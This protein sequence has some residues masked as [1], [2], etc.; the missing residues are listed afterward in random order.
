[1]RNH[2]AMPFAAGEATLLGS[3]VASH[4]N[5]RLALVVVSLL[6]AAFILTV[7]AASRPFP[8]IPAFVPTYNA[9]VMILSLITAVL[10]YSQYCELK[11]RSLLALVSGYLFM[12][13]MVA[14]HGI[15][16]PG[17][18]GPGHLIGGRQTS[19][20][21]WIAWHGL[22]PLFVAA[23]ALFAQRERRDGK[24]EARAATHRDTVFAF[25]GTL[26]LAAALILLT[27]AGEAL[28][29]ELMLGH[30]Y[31]SNFPRLIMSAAWGSH[32]IALGLLIKSTRG[33]RVIDLWVGVTL[34]SATIDL[35][36]SGIFVT[37]RYQLGFYVGR[38]YEL[39]ASSFVLTL[40][41]RQAVRL[42]G[43]L[44]RAMVALRAS[45]E[46][47][48][49]LIESVHDYAIFTLDPDG[50]VMSWNEGA[51][52][53]N[54][55]TTEE[56]IGR[57]VECFYTQED[58]AAGK[59]RREMET[60]LET[61]HSEN[62]SWRVRKDGSLF[63]AN[64]VMT[65]LKADDGALLGFTKISRDLTERKQL[66]DA[67]RRSH[68]DLDQR[69]RERTLELAATNRQLEGEVQERRAAEE[70]VKIL[71]R[72]LVTAQEE[73]RRRIA[74]DI[75]DQ[76]GQQM[77]ALRMSLSTL[78]FKCDKRTE[79]TEH[80]RRTEELANDLDRSIDFLTW[81]LRPAGLEHFSLSVALGTLVD[82]WS[83]YFQIMAEYFA[84]GV[85]H[86][87]L[88]PEAE[89][90]L[91]RLAQEALHNIYKHAE[92]S[93]VGVMFERHGDLVV[94]VIED[95]GRGFNPEE[96]RAGQGGTGMGLIGMR[97]RAALAGGKL[98]VESSP[99]VGTTIYVQI[100]LRQ[101]GANER[102]RN[103]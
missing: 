31:R 42:H 69:V 86:L 67:L 6:G 47:L 3:A 24:N 70:R 2:I 49:G 58:V 91:Y 19:V 84:S 35:A 37:G 61:G 83:G 21:L 73:E 22:F 33:R 29:P 51:R 50:R 16:F 46:R 26:A 23:Y 89:I 93:H 40:L 72:Q 1:M 27:T 38:I 65:P 45:E 79:L 57:T 76:M 100:S 44:A 39:L 53:I 82:G 102:K 15:S 14:A 4:E 25:L 52:R 7:P 30:N 63:W 68:D 10:L 13:I 90:N 66:E 94:L 11:E 60:A 85:D 48:R 17:A 74:R 5:R 81:E 75:H 8:V 36:L 9:S 43:R 12:M 20:W 59:P 103:E 99:Q 95:N 80:V 78:A 56:I 71:L 55:Y 64:E 92:A 32:F 88:P 87:R 28:L 96:V 77:T 41:L 18:F 54:G 101:D 62:E 97:E 34:L 98:Q